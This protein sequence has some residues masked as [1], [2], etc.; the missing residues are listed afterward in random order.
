MRGPDEKAD[1]GTREWKVHAAQKH[2]APARK[3]PQSC[4][5]PYVIA[6]IA[7]WYRTLRQRPLGETPLLLVQQ[8]SICEEHGVGFLEQSLYLGIHEKIHGGW[9]GEY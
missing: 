3:P 9:S 8:L 4:S 6:F 7:R 2:S 1:E 5:L